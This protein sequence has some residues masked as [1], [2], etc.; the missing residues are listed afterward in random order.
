MSA[1]SALPH[2]PHLSTRA[3]TLKT[4][5]S[6]NRTADDASLDASLESASSG[7]GS[8]VRCE[9]ACEIERS[10][11]CGR[12][13][14]GAGGMY[15][16][17]EHPSPSDP[18]A[19]SERRTSKKTSAAK[20]PC[21]MQRLCGVAACLGQHPGRLG[22]T[23]R[24]RYGTRMRTRRTCSVRVKHFVCWVTAPRQHRCCRSP[25]MGNGAYRVFLRLALGTPR[26]S[27]VTGTFSCGRERPD[28]QGCN[29]Q[30][31]NDAARR[32]L[33]LRQR[34]AGHIGRSQA[35]V[36]TKPT[37]PRW[38]G[39]HGW[40]PR[41]T[42]ADCSARRPGGGGSALGADPCEARGALATHHIL[43][44]TLACAACA[45]LLAQR[46]RRIRAQTAGRWSRHCSMW[47][48]GEATQ[49]RACACV[50]ACESM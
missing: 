3:G 4:A 24:P 19:S 2:S 45:C 37:H 23:T 43:S 1:G 26:L 50:R 22:P 10:K 44:H 7:S 48:G 35:V 36:P 33:L 21:G 42:R 31:C 8:V 12:V 9:S 46:G 20:K 6:A 13:R 30:R 32:R 5:E 17:D 16:G 49:P 18:S 39:S 40:L 34:T 15:G 11:E 47:L 14:V 38:V 28:I 25:W 29:M 27:I 41:S